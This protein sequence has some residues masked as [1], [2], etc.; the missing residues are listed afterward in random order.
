MDYVIG[1]DVGT[2]AAK[3]VL[4]S[5]AGIVPLKS[6]YKYNLIKE[7]NG[8]I[9]QDPEDWYK[10]V[11]TLCRSCSKSLPGDGRITAIAFSTQGGS[12]VL[13]DE[14]GMNKG[15]AI[16]WMD[17]RG[18]TE[19]LDKEAL[20]RKTG[21]GADGNLVL[22]QLRRMRDEAPDIFNDACKVL[23]T[24]DYLAMRLT[25]RAVID[26]TNAAMTQLADYR[27]GMWD[28]ELCSEA[29]IDEKMLPELLS[30]GEIIGPL[31]EKALADTGLTGKVLLINGAHDQ[32]A[33]ALGAG[34]VR[35]GDV[36]CSTGTTWVVMPVTDKPAESLCYH[37]GRHV[38]PGLYGAIATMVTGGVCM[39]WVLNILGLDYDTANK[40]VSETCY[41]D[42]MFMPFLSGRY[43]PESDLS[44]RGSFCGLSL[45]HKKGDIIRAVMEGLALE[46]RRMTDGFEGESSK[47]VL[48][49]GATKSK[50]WTQILADITGRE[51][52]SAGYDNACAGAAILA[53]IAVGMF[54]NVEEALSLTAG[55]NIIKPLND[56]SE[57]YN[58]YKKSAEAAL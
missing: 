48:T 32:Y 23:T 33:G 57:K 45:S 43:Y 1:I 11:C 22:C 9:L 3:A 30:A 25:G 2:T 40:L 56:C 29:G 47:L 26:S 50:V 37:P 54:K 8:E 6:V 39:D 16:S 20:L 21:W 7:N 58:R 19:G 24:A 5:K 13:T 46:L 17:T 12:L 4:L 36:I 52:L 49:G 44:I 41:T 18:K 51:I 55:K 14:N 35:A 42:V 31:T 27:K 34:A 28:A 53:G 10:A 15:M 38:I